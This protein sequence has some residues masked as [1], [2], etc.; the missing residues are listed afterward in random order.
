[1]CLSS[2]PSCPCSLSAHVVM[3][4]YWWPGFEMQL[5]RELQRQQN[6]AQLCDTLLQTEGEFVC[7]SLQCWTRK[8]KITF[9][10]I[11]IISKGISV[12]AHSCVLAALSP[13]LSEKLSASPP[14]PSGQKRQLQLRTVKA[15]TLLKL[16]GLLYSGELEVKGS[17]EQNDVL[18]AARQFGIADLVE[19]Q[20][21]LGT[22]EGEK[23]RKSCAS[24]IE[25]NESRKIQDTRVQAEMA[26]SRAAEKRSC[27]STNTR[28]VK[29]GE[30]KVGSLSLTHSGQTKTPVQEP[31]SSSAQPLNSS[32]M[33]Q[34]QN[35]TL[36]KHIHTTCFPPVHNMHRW[37][38]SDGDST[39]SSDSLPKP[40]S[41]SALSSDVMSFP[42][43]L[44][45]D[46][47]S[48]TPQEDS[49]YQQS[50]EFGDMVG[51]SSGEEKTNPKTADRRE[52]TERASTAGRD[53]ILGE[54]NPTEKK[55]AH[56]NA[57]IRNMPKMK[58]M[59]KMMESTQISIKVRS[60]S[61]F[62]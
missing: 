35:T 21:D 45:E 52:N 6:N 49:S 55:L 20:K 39:L 3:Q 9:S 23:Q 59:Q 60:G 30:K 27:V 10:N 5:L 28:T 25:R 8:C 54:E 16:V 31:A 46:S 57:G 47:N 11:S 42:I 58:Q 22:N 41:T 18:S 29:V 4:R 56:A 36:H 1:M 53:E 40:T 26:G 7:S 34:P 14:P 51:T 48:P 62:M 12:P 33:L 44:N 24:C 32:I 43:P 15:Q 17:V 19:R 61:F 13:Y 50:S 37:A 2:P 38:P